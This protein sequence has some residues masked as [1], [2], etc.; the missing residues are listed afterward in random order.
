MKKYKL[1]PQD[2]IDFKE[3]M[4]DGNATKI[5]EDKYLEQTTQYT[6]E[7]T[8]DELRAFFKREFRSDNSY[9]TGG[10]SSNYEIIEDADGEYQQGAYFVVDADT[11]SMLAYFDF[12]KEA[13]NYLKKVKELGFRNVDPSEFNGQY[14]SFMTDDSMYRT[15]GVSVAHEN[16]E[17]LRNQ[18][19]EA[20]HHSK[21]LSS[22]VSGSTPVEPWVVAKMERATTDLSD[23]THYIEGKNKMKNSGT[24]KMATGKKL[25]PGKVPRYWNKLVREYEYFVFNTRSNKV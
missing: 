8:L 22:V 18:I 2:E 19:S 24:E 7:F 10:V 11:D 16:N 23:V 12:K 13:S 15:G 14:A 5:G 9:R 6:K 4:E 3:W 25:E 20:N 21:E 1:T 17:M